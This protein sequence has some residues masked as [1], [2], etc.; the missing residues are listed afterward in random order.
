MTIR[1]VAILLLSA[2]SCVSSGDASEAQKAN[3]SRSHYAESVSM[4]TG[5]IEAQWAAIP[6]DRLGLEGSGCY[7]SCPEYRVQLFRGGQATYEGDRF[8][9][10]QGA[11][12]GAVTLYD[13]GLLS[14]LAR[15]VGLLE[16]SDRYSAQWTDDETITFELT[17]AHGD[18]VISDYG[19]QGPPELQA[20]RA[21]FESVVDRIRWKPTDAAR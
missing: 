8:A 21:L 6:F 20:F 10:R 5:D 9:P 16:M 17:G 3:G 19:R 2:T 1:F 14:A 4:W 13:Y 12:V 11:Y 18:K 7:G 15:R